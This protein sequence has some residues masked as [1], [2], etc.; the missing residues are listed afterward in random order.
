MSGPMRRPTNDLPLPADAASGKGQGAPP[1]VSIHE[2][3]VRSGA[4]ER[5]DRYLAER[6]PLSR[7]RLAALIRDGRVSVNGGRARK[8]YAVEAGDRI[9]VRVPAPSVTR[10]EPE[11]IPVSIR[12]EDQDLAVVEKPAD[13][14]VHPAPGH[15]SG[16]LVNA[17]LHHL[18]GLSSVGG[19]WRPGI[20]HRLDKDTSGLMVVARSDEAHLALSRALARR[21][22]RRGYLTATWGH[23]DEDRLTIDR[24]IGRDPR[25]RKKMAVREDGRPAVTHVKRLERWN[26][27]DLL[28][29]RLQTGRTHQVRVH[30][31]STGHPIVG[32][33]VY[34]PGWERGFLGAGGRWAEELGRRAG[35]LFL[36]AAHLSFEH[37]R[38]GER[39][40]FT[41]PLPEPLASAAAW[42]RETS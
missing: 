36:H 6:L 9:R 21:E 15:P 5:L 38:S 10:L 16:T 40:S 31:H 35:R 28:A 3:E 25:D 19:E 14:V 39:L 22:V 42:A 30:L 2:F 17:L 33:P 8:S 13:L 12:H 23:I 18:G 29:I 24:P 4:G 41:S 34:G 32:D 7:T 11:P 37:P 20:V 1:D 27:A 26:A